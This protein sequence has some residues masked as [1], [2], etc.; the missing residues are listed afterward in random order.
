M[1]D[2][3]WLLVIVGGPVIIG[4]AIAFGMA[5]QRRLSTSQREAQHRATDRLYHAD[6]ADQ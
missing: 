4:A 2:F 6:S 1:I 3:L 5:R